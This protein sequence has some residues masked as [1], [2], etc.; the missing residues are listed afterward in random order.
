MLIIAFNY[1]NKPHGKHSPNK[2][3]GTLGQIDALKKIMQAAIV[4][5]GLRIDS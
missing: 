4:D 1:R 3:S 2:S 5:K